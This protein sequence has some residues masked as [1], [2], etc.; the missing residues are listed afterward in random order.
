MCGEGE[1]KHRHSPA[2]G[3]TSPLA[4]MVLSLPVSLALSVKLQRFDN[5]I[6]NG[7]RGRPRCEIL[8]DAVSRYPHLF[9]L[10]W[11]FLLHDGQDHIILSR[12]LHYPSL[13][14]W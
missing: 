9:L 8:A 12:I 10:I 13:P 3:H 11:F 1:A 2:T 4:V 5:G 6:F 14:V 7:F